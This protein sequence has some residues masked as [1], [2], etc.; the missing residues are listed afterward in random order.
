M[1]RL[2]FLCLPFVAI[3]TGFAAAFTLGDLVVVRVG[4]GAALNNTATAASLLEYSTA[5][6]LIQTIA[7]PTAASAGVNPLTLQG[8]ATSEGFLK[9]SANGNYLTMAGYAATPGTATP[10]SST[11]ATVNRVVGRID[12]A[13]NINTTTA[14]IDAYDASNVRGAV[15]TDGNSLWL[16]GNST[17]S[18]GI[19]YTTLGSTT[20]IGLNTAPLNARVVDVVNGQLY[21]GSGSG[22]F[23]GPATVGTGTPTTSGQTYTL[24]PGFPTSGTHSPYDFWFK[25]ANT[26]YVADDGTAVN[27]GGIQKWALSLGT[28]SLQ[29]TLLNNG[30]TTTGVRG[31]TGTLDGSG[32]AVLFGTTSAAL[33]SLIMLTDTGAGSTATTLATVTTGY[34]F[35]GV[36]FIPVPEPSSLALLLVGAAGLFFP[37]VSR[38]R[39]QRGL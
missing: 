14:L 16:S 8:T 19:R 15:S 33:T 2:V 9:L 28:W 31:L 29:Y 18:G 10:A 39:R 6:S 22:G 3:S 7:L 32:N 34:A 25:D 27:G 13:G 37:F 21:A 12:M 5:G 23:T 26:V 30:T 20:T 1:K 11:A 17:T 24:F 38:Q 36:E 4:T 35:R